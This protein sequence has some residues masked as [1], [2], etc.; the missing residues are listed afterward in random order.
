[1]GEHKGLMIGHVE[2]SAIAGVFCLIAVCTSAWHIRTHLQRFSRP[3]HQ[4]QIVRI[5]LMVPVY[6]LGSWLSLTFPAQDLYFD[7]IRDCY[8]AFTIYSFLQL[9]LAY[10]GGESV[11]CEH[12][13]EKEQ[14]MR[15]IFVCGCCC[16]PI[17]LDKSFLRRCKQ[18]CIQFVIAKPVLA[19]LVLVLNGFDEYHKDDWSMNYGF[20][21]VQVFYNISYT[22]ALYTLANFYQSTEAL[23]EPYKPVKKFMMV[24]LII[25]VSFW[26]GL[27]ISLMVSFDA[28]H[29]D[30]VASSLQ[31]FLICIEMAFA[32]MLHVVAFPPSEYSAA[33]VKNANKSA[34]DN[35]GRTVNVRD[36]MSDAYNNFTTTYREYELQ[37]EKQKDATIHAKSRTIQRSFVLTNE[38]LDQLEAEDEKSPRR[39]GHCDSPEGDDEDGNSMHMV[40]LGN[41]SDDE[42]DVQRSRVMNGDAQ[43]G[44]R[45]RQASMES[46]DSPRDT[47]SAAEETDADNVQLVL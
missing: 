19:I 29:G 40:S 15:S 38:A 3:D 9:L 21:W 6:A 11:A 39:S 12:Y 7:S 13:R 27:A 14:M 34:M 18:G 23:L 47:K 25:F 16:A 35:L 1:M 17:S 44:V 10:M 36:V 41:D 46:M 33:D 28:V 30:G 5:L 24:K 42:E 43:N 45:D 26:Q 2:E 31:S 20:V 8:E 37:G 22:W 32:A 4:K